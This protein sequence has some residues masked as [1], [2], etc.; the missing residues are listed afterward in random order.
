MEDVSLSAKRASQA[1]STRMMIA[2]RLNSSL[3]A[4]EASAKFWIPADDPV[5]LWRL[6]DITAL[7]GDGNATLAGAPEGEEPETVVVSVAQPWDERGHIY[8]AA[9]NVLCSINPYRDLGGDV[10]DVPATLEAMVDTFGGAEGEPH[11]FRWAHVAYD[12][13]WKAEGAATNQAIICNGESGAGKTMAST[14]IAFGNAKTA[15]NDNSSRFGKFLL[16]EYEDKVLLCGLGGAAGETYGVASADRH[17]YLNQHELVVPGDDLA[18]AGDAAEAFAALGQGEAIAWLRRVCAGLVRLGD[19]DFEDVFDDSAEESKNLESSEAALADAARALQVAAGDLDGASL[20]GALHHRSIVVAG[21]RKRIPFTAAQARNARDALAKA[22]YEKLFDHVV[23]LCNGALAPEAAAVSRGG[24]DSDS[25]E[26]GPSAAEV[27]ASAARAFVGI[28][29]IY[30]FEIMASNSLDQLLINFANETLQVAFNEQVLVAEG[31]R[32]REE[33]IACPAIDLADSQRCLDLIKAPPYGVLV[34]LDEQVKLGQRGSDMNF[35][36]C[37]DKANKDHPFYA[38]SRTN[39]DKFVVRHYAGDVA[40]TAHGFLTRNVD[41]LSGD[42]AECLRSSKDG[43]LA[44]WYPAAGG[45]E[46]AR[47]AQ[48]RA[49]SESTSKKFREQMAALS[50]ELDECEKHYVRCIRPNGSKDRAVFDMDMVLRQ[51]R[52]FG[53]LDIVKIRRLGYPEQS[54]PATFWKSYWQLIPES[55][56]DHKWHAFE[57]LLPA[58]IEALEA[59]RTKAAGFNEATKVAALAADLKAVKEKLRDEHGEC[60]PPDVA[61]A[62]VML[63]TMLLDDGEFAIG[64]KSGQLFTKLGV[65]RRLDEMLALAM[66][67]EAATSEERA[68]QLSALASDRVDAEEKA[69]SVLQSISRGRKQVADA[70]EAAERAA[71]KVEVDDA[72]FLHTETAD[73]VFAWCA[74]ATIRLVALVDAADAASRAALA[75]YDAA[76]GDVRQGAALHAL[77]HRLEDAAGLGIAVPGVEERS[78]VKAPAADAI[79]ALSAADARDAV[80]AAAL[81]S[82]DALLAVYEASVHEGLHAVGGAKVGAAVDAA[83]DALAAAEA[84]VAV[85]DDEATHAVEAAEAAVRGEEALFE[86]TAKT[87]ALNDLEEAKQKRGVLVARA[88]RAPG[89]VLALPDLA[90]ALARQR[91]ATRLQAWWR[92]VDERGAYHFVLDLTK[93]WASVIRD[94]HPRARDG[95][96]HE[97]VV[98]HTIVLWHKYTQAGRVGEFIGSRKLHM[99][100][101]SEKS[102]AKSSVT[103]DDSSTVVDPSSLPS[104]REHPLVITA[105]GGAPA[106]AAPCV[107]RFKHK[108]G[109]KSSNMHLT[110]LCGT[111]NRWVTLKMVF[112]QRAWDSFTPKKTAR[113]NLDV[114]VANLP[115]DAYGFLYKKPF[116]RQ[117]R[118]LANAPPEPPPADAPSPATAARRTKSATRRASAALEGTKVAKE[119]KSRFFI[120]QGGMLRYFK[121][122]ADDVPKGQLCLPERGPGGNRPHGRAAAT[123]APGPEDGQFVVKTPELPEGLVVRGNDAADAAAWMDAIAA[124]A[125]TDLAKKQDRIKR[126]ETIMALYGFRANM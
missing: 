46:E 21:S 61:E 85:G 103:V 4:G 104:G 56:G 119:E 29:D 58:T 37:V 95:A 45:G 108:Q 82:A 28:L 100:R 48:R 125:A 109:F 20:R 40:Y 114:S 84:Q 65:T 106:A 122:E 102:G 47:Q 31:E 112:D 88:R 34:L 110:D 117:T 32:Y 2:A 43:V 105:A 35:L 50:E 83:R 115:V 98:L 19:V 27:E 66:G 68:A 5:D 124:A 36:A 97:F 8:T 24:G 93:K 90:E 78:A 30:G 87:R 77:K 123:V 63:C 7:D 51:L 107:F 12:A 101:S 71:L 25:D 44:A 75:A 81:A 121:H 57:R 41:P 118:D 22:L 3:E 79:A 96:I 16:L 113:L 76:A 17:H 80:A 1:Q 69:S 54:D 55:V 42:A 10:Y 99:V 23:R 9:G 18:E 89:D 33:G 64:T 26:E 111:F 116:K 6:V 49:L 67:L 15:M 92:C 91:A 94:A 11:L 53:L 70:K 59:E 39:P 72:A 74:S 126:K 73:A 14:L 86:T 60:R 52:F 120:L 38:K 62:C 13:L